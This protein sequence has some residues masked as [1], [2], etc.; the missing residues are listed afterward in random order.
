[1]IPPIRRRDPYPPWST[2]FILGFTGVR[3]IVSLAAALALPLTVANGEPFPYRDLILFLSFVVVL[4]TLVGQGLTL[5]WVI[6]RLR[7]AFAGRRE[8][9]AERVQEFGAR[10]QAIRAALKLL[11]TLPPADFPEELVRP[12]RNHHRNRLR[13]TRDRDA[14]HRRLLELDDGIEILVIAAEREAINNLYR[15]G[16]LK[17]EARR[18]IEREL[19]L[20]AADIDNRREE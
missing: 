18:R 12:Q 15:D 16:K 13:H 6:R 14:E 10:Q 1:L 20:R 9:R 5:P 2:P 17:D 4:V 11:D 7:L 19:D 8:R 3:G